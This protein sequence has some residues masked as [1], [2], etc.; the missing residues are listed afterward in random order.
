MRQTATVTRPPVAA[1]DYVLDPAHTRVGFVSRHLMVTKV[2]GSFG[3]VD[4]RVRIGQNLE[5]SS[6][7]VTIDVASVAT[8]DARRDA[9]LL[10][11]DFF[12]AERFPQM[13]FRSTA[14]EWKGDNRYAI[15]GALTIRDQTHPVTLNAEYL[16]TENSPWGIRASALSAAVEIDREV[17]GLS[18]NVALESG[19]VLVGKRIQ[20]E[21]DAEVLPA[22]AED[23]SV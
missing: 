11:A 23:S 7:A 16:G 14:I 20:L 18:W 13:T 2:R 9:H 3:K 10:S 19:G 6:V 1:G 8:G 12:D 17:W 15:T 5:D 22:P 4:G 21:I